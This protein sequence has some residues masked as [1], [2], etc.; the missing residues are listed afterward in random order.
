[1][2]SYLEPPYLAWYLIQYLAIIL[3]ITTGQQWMESDRMR[4]GC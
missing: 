1:M 2:L 4:Y 3:H